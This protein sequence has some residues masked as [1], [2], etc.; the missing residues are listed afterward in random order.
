MVV[1]VEKEG[2]R[3][4]EVKLGQL[5][6]PPPLEPH[7]MDDLRAHTYIHIHTTH[8]KP[9]SSIHLFI[10]SSKSPSLFL[11]SLPSPLPTGL[12]DFI[13]SFLSFLSPALNYFFSNSLFLLISSL[14]SSPF[15][16][17]LSP[18]LSLPPCLALLPL[19]ISL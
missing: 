5:R 14:V 7:L 6:H 18:F 11:L 10:Y 17:L 8:P 1:V 4:E 19:S 3:W 13:L 12:F 9:L 2:G 16:H 15:P